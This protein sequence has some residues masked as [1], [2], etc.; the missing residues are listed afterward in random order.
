MWRLVLVSPRAGLVVL[1]VDRVVLGAGCARGFC[2]SARATDLGLEWPAG[3]PRPRH[4]SP[5]SP[6]SRTVDGRVSAPRCGY[7][8]RATA[9]RQVSLVAERGARRG[10]RG[11]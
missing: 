1:S 9:G 4:D 8:S 3:M 7:R 6:A 10:L 2:S 5:R 11:T